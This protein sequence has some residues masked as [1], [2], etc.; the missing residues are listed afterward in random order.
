LRARFQ[1][2]LPVW[3]ATYFDFAGLTIVS[4]FNPR[5]PC[6]ERR[7]IARTI[8]LERGVSI[9]APRVGS[10][11]TGAQLPHAESTLPVWGATHSEGEEYNLA[12]VSI[13]APRVGSDAN[14]ARC[15]H[16]RGAFQSTLPVW[17]ATEE[18]R[19]LSMA[20]SAFQSTLPVWGATGSAGAPISLAAFQSTLPVWGATGIGCVLRGSRIVS[21]HAPRVGSDGLRAPNPACS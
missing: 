14:V 13:H 5:S 3:G 16:C 4:G 8:R 9:H 19:S 21:I 7:H 10:D 15:K 1:S 17:G 12:P 6:G 20:W 2:T 11:A 18:V